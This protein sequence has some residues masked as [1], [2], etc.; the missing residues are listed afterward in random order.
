MNA[1]TAKDTKQ[2]KQ[3]NPAETIAHAVLR[4]VIAGGGTGGHL[5]P[6]I[7][8]ADEFM[9]WNQGN[10]V[11]FISSGNPF[12]K[13]I[14]SKT[15]FNL[16][17]IT[18]EGIKGR[19]ICK[20]AM[21]LLKFPKGTFE[22]V[23]ILKSFRPDLVVGVG[24][25]SSG[26][27]VIAAWLLGIKIVLHEQNILPGITNRILSRFADKIFVSFNGMAPF[28]R[29][30]KLI[31][32]G[33]PIRKEFLHPVNN[34]KT[35]AV[36]DEDHK[37]PFSIL[38]LGGSQGAHRINTAVA[39]ALMYLKD[40]TAF[41]FVHQAGP[42]DIEMVKKAYSNHGIS[43]TVQSF[44]IDMDQQYRKADL[45]IC[46]A[47]ATTIAEITAIGKAV[48]FIPF[49][50]A[51]D[52]H[53]TLN[54]RMLTERGAAEMILQRDLNGE[55]LAKRIEY[56]ASN[57]EMLTQLASKAKRLGK[58]EAAKLIVNKCYRLFNIDNFKP[59]LIN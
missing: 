9:S 38:I 43:S 45:I 19:G 26:P 12:E 41:H 47:G 34:H 35:H 11:L 57:P 55:R 1:Q 30:D 53:Q 21:S 36:I 46:R 4:I 25:Y 20:Q 17:T 33:N 32:S 28:F 40:R 8:I 58:P 23:K 39:E 29:T 7:A 15:D 56:Y 52:D 27:V 6:G 5:F 10:Q 42:Q 22:S 48:I 59:D 14:L 54:A 24:S 49:P 50:F 51:A 44:F 13:S 3:Q 31:F 16:A 18:V 37:P 2:V